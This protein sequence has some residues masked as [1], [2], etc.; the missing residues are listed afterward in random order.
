MYESFEDLKDKELYDL[1][2][3]SLQNMLE[4]PDPMGFGGNLCEIKVQLLDM[5]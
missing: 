2:H 4:L 1:M 3:L 5:H